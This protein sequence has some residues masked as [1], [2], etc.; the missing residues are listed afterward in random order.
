MRTALCCAVCF[1]LAF[2]S[3]AAAAEVTWK[4][5]TIN[6]A[7]EFPACA[8]FDV[9]RDRARRDLPLL[10]DDLHELHAAGGHTG[11][12]ELAR[13]DRLAGTAVLPQNI[14][15]LEWRSLFSYPEYD[16]APGPAQASDQARG[17]VSSF[18]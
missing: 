2:A 12:E 7:S 9:D 13:I 5:H 6:A 18:M 8:A 1:W 10:G 17:Q 4:M 11:E 14:L 16:R 15:Y 3:Y